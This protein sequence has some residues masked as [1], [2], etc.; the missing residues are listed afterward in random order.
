MASPTLYGTGW[1]PDPP[2]DRDLA[3]D[4]G[5]VRELL[6][7]R[8]VHGADPS[9]LPE[10][11]DLA[12]WCPPVRFQGFYD[13]CTAHVVTGMIEL[14][15][16]K[17]SGSYVA[18][19]RLFLY[20]VAKRLL[21]ETG[22][23]GL[24]LRQTLGAAVLLGVPPEKYFPYLDTAVKDDPRIDAEPDAFCYAL[25]RDY[26][27]A[28]Y[29]R[30]DVPGVEPAQV[31]ERLKTCLAASMPCSLG[32]SLYAASLAAAGS[33]GELAMPARGEPP[34]ASHAVL[35][36]GYD[37]AREVPVTA[38]G[39][40]AMGPEVTTGAFRFQNS[41]G[42]SWGDAGFGWLPY[43]YLTVGLARDCW[44]MMQALWLESGEFGLGL[45]SRKRPAPNG[46][47]PAEPTPG[48]GEPADHSSAA[49]RR[50]ASATRSR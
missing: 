35:L 41:W 40:R 39:G 32:L 45:E 31:V 49:S 48:G 36:M 8:G 38:A 6:A 18:A 17:A 27:G 29:F 11:V 3:F 43:R 4:D 19:S 44:T 30:I 14:L 33:T 46:S 22:D 42:T 10:R 47:A 21:G 26:G 15:E 16:I 9:R 20:Q 25:A 24:Y 1:R 2:D 28:K 37:D 50:R 5:A 12:A 7:G 13:T 23:P 34:V